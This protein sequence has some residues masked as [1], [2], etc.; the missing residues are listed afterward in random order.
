[1]TL[2]LTGRV[3]VISSYGPEGSIPEDQLFFIG[4][5]RSVRGFGEN[6]LSTDEQDAPLGGKAMLAG[7]AEVQ[8]GLS[9]KLE[10]VLFTDTGSLGREVTDLG[11]VF[12]S[13]SGLGLRYLSPVGPV[14]LQYGWKLDPREGEPPG[15]VH[16]SMG[17]TF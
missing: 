2:V 11:G 10:L 15:Q 7:S 12:R 9:R 8:L 14:S 6:L 5:T 17:S 3:G 4:G 16:F 13:S 1:I